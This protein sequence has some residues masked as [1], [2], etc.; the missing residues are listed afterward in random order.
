MARWDFSKSEKFDFH[1]QRDGEGY[2]LIFEDAKRHVEVKLSVAFLLKV[3]SRLIV[4]AASKFYQGGGEAN[5][6]DGQS[7]NGDGESH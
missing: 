2:I 4:E 5:A 6:G 3:I 7:A 1:V